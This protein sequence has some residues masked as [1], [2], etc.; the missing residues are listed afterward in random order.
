MEH[1][2]YAGFR[3][4]SVLYIDDDP[5][6][7]EI[8]KMY[9]EDSGEFHIDTVE[10]ATRAL[11]I[12]QHHNYDAVISDYQMPEMDGIEFL[13]NLRKENPLIPVIIFTGKDREE[14]A[15]AAVENGAD[16]YHQKG[17]DPEIQ[18]AELS[19]K[20]RKS[21]EQ[22][23]T[24]LAIRKSGIRHRFE[25]VPCYTRVLDNECRVI[26]DSPSTA[27]ILGYPESFFTGKIA[28]D[29]IH[30]ED[31]ETATAAFDRVRTRTNPGTPTGFR[32]R[33]A[34]GTYISVESVAMNL[35]GVTGVD[36]IVVTTWIS[37]GKKGMNR[38]FGT[39]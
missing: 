7:L 12:L 39:N 22:Y 9:L 10:S 33:K 13:R 25:T 26:C 11:D 28:I 30:P 32:L 34:N 31:R 14:I 16:S 19:H 6:L 3:M 37:P 29:F 27:Y 1:P 8:S 38:Y 2:V 4:I 23:P 21:V 17:G 20:I 35:T 18:F 15:F 5:S 36:G 24:K